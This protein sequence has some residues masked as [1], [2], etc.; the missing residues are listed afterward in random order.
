M[1]FACTPIFLTAC[2]LK[3]SRGGEDS[4]AT[5]NPALPSQSPTTDPSSPA[6]NIGNSTNNPD[7]K[8]VNAGTFAN[9][10]A[11]TSE[12]PAPTPTPSPT[13]TPVPLQQVV[14]MEGNFS[15]GKTNLFLTTGDLQNLNGFQKMGQLTY[16]LQKKSY[17]LTASDV[18]TSTTETILNQDSFPV[19]FGG[20]G[21]DG[22][23]L[24]AVISDT[25]AGNL[26]SG[27]VSNAPITFQT[28]YKTVCTSF[29]SINFGPLSWQ[30]STPAYFDGIQYSCDFATEQCQRLAFGFSSPFDYYTL[31][32][33]PNHYRCLNSK[34]DFTSS[35]TDYNSTTVAFVTVT[36]DPNQKSFSLSGQVPELDGLSVPTSIVMTF[37]ENILQFGYPQ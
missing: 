35:E 30:S 8:S 21:E 37:S 32:N 6:N 1:L 28:K 17:T 4:T 27:T 13:P 31:K 12:S 22:I 29:V 24:I 9:S 15:L 33:D 25:A 36:L 23:H 20:K 7:S 2:S 16:G 14:R 5:Q 3:S 34:S 19:Y 26:K 10:V 11:P 18:P